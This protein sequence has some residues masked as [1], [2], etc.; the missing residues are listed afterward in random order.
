MFLK[1]L[2]LL[3]VT[4][5]RDPMDILY[6]SGE[7]TIPTL[8]SLDFWELAYLLRAAIYIVALI[9]I[10]ASLIS[11]LYVRNSN[12]VAEKKKAIT[13][14]LMIVFIVGSAVFLFNTLKDFF[15]YFL[16]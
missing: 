9:S 6:A 12:M 13:H 2:P 1:S 8:K 16:F 7:N 11:L 10:A 4:V 14:K 15:D 3:D 5:I